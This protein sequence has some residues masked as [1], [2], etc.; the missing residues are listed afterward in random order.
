MFGILVELGPL[1]LND[2]SLQTADYRGTGVPSLFY[3]PHGWSRLGGLLMF[4]WPPPVGFSYCHDP[5]SGGLS[6]GAWDDERMA[7]ASYAAL[8]GWCVPG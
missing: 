1:L 6:C 8:A 7:K 2:D 4:D 5:S 3:N